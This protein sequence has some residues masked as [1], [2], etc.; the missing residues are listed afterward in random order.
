LHLLE[1]GFSAKLESVSQ[2]LAKQLAA[3]QSESARYALAYGRFAEVMLESYSLIPNV[4]LVVS[5]VYEDNGSPKQQG[6]AY[7][8][9]SNTARNLFHTYL[10]A[11]DRDLRPVVQ[12]DLDEF[13]SE[14]R[15]SSVETACRSYTKQCFE[16][17]YS[18]STLF[19]KLFDIDV[20]PNSM[21]GSAHAALKSG[22]RG[23]VNAANLR[24]L[25]ANLQA[26]LQGAA[27]EQISHFVAWLAN[28]YLLLEHDEEESPFVG[29]CRLY[30]ASLLS[31]YL[32]AFTDNAFDSEASRSITKAVV[33]ADSLKVGPV[34]H[35]LASSNAHV[36]TKR[37]L[38]LLAL[39][40]QCMP[41][42][43]CVSHTPSSRGKVQY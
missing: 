31:E 33:P 34:A 25:A 8:I 40:D 12:Q 24:P 6:N 21:P 16:R 26:V 7:D 3:T 14:T 19:A 41:K 29:Q 2:E 30:T 1:V 4:Q 35:G 10:T 20:Q 38:E 23:L 43:R 42:E 32:W 37:A 39:Y 5:R 13:R 28:E 15:S 36:I 22:Q 18:E 17:A 9:F 27:L 11:R